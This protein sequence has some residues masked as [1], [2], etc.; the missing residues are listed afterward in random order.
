MLPNN[1]RSINQMVLG[2]ASQLEI[3]NGL[4]HGEADYGSLDCNCI[5]CD[6]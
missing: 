3:R 2:M 5:D 6:S 1:W 4:P